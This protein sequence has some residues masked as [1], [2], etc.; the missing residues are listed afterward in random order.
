MNHRIVLIITKIMI[1]I[2]LNI[3][4]KIRMQMQIQKK[5]KSKNINKRKK[6]LIV[7]SYENITRYFKIYLTEQFMKEIVFFNILIIFIIFVINFV[8]HE[9]V[10]TYM[11]ED[12]NF[13]IFSERA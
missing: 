1:I 13:R 11:Y 12:R 9:D 5:I 8:I 10:R 7:N 2:V 4:I 6:N 3:E